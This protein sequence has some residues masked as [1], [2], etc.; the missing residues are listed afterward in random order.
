HQSFEAI[1]QYKRNFIFSLLSEISAISILIIPVLILQ[2]E[3][4]IETLISLYALAFTIKGIAS[5]IYYR[6]DFTNNLFIKKSITENPYTYKNYFISSFPFLL[7]TLAGM[8]Q[9]RMDLYGV[10]YFM[11]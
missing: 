6:K 3:L 8:L 1:T 11:D 7:L 9:S 10:A 4:T 5:I 2:R